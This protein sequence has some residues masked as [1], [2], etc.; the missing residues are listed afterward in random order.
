MT[1]SAS[2]R[3][4]A[5]AVAAFLCIAAASARVITAQDEPP[6]PQAHGH[7]GP[8]P[9]GRGAMGPPPGQRGLALERLSRELGIT[10]TQKAFIDA[11]LADQR[12]TLSLEA[13][14]LRKAR[15]ALDA[16][17]LNVPTDDGL[18]QAEV[19]QISTLEAQL[20]LGRART[21]AKIF[22]LLNTEQQAKVRQLIAEM[23]HR[24][25]RR[26]GRG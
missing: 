19:L 23:E 13:E 18:I 21:Q 2:R 8:G 9:G 24:G 12:K 20:A 15:Q 11:L 4:R 14:T 7:S 26:G 5:S 25:P 17:V 1:T 10:D 6:Q 16:A 3:L 22:Q